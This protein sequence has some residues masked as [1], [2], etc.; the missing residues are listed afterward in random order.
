MDDALGIDEDGNT[1]TPITALA[2]ILGLIP[3]SKTSFEIFQPLLMF[4]DIFLC[5]QIFILPEM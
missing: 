3:C 4:K 5:P 2:Y 1:M